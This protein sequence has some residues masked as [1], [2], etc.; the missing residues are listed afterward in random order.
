[1]QFVTRVGCIGLGP[2][3]LSFAALAKNVPSVFLECWEARKKF[4]WHPGLLLPN[5]YMQTSPLKDLVTLADPTHPLSFLSFLKD[6]G[7]LFTYLN[8]KQKQVK[9]WEFTAYMQWAA[10]QLT[11]IRYN[12]EVKDVLWSQEKGFCVRTSS[13]MH[14]VQNL[15]IGAGLVPY[16][17]KFVERTTIPVIH[18]SRFLSWD[19]QQLVKKRVVIVGGGQSATDIVAYLLDMDIDFYAL[20]WINSRN[21]WWSLDDS[22]FV[23]ELFSPRYTHYFEHLKPHKRAHVLRAQRYADRGI[24]LASLEALYEKLYD[25]RFREKKKNICLLPSTEAIGFSTENPKALIC[26]QKE[27]EKEFVVQADVLIMATGY[28]NKIPSFLKSIKENMLFEDPETPVLDAHY[29]V[30]WRKK[31]HAKLYFQSGVKRQKGIAEDNLSLM[32][33]RSA[34]ILNDI[35]GHAYYKLPDQ[36][37]LQFFGHPSINFFD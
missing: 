21:S 22:P 26:L 3:N 4:N 7:R 11:S 19:F 13:G 16:L 5:A 23:N 18:S 24:S 1:M 36:K 9:R 25:Y 37:A 30:A 8:A 31:W 32:S 27:M 14:Y 33:Y 34:Q 6:K 29:K 35:V 20:T 12:S 2:F 10:A 17:P 28:K 15:V